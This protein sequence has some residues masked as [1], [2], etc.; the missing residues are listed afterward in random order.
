ME[1][2]EEKKLNVAVVNLEVMKLNKN[3]GIYLILNKING[4]GYVG[5][6]SQLK[7]RKKQHFRK[8]SKNIHYND[9]LQNAF[10]K[11]GEDSFRFLI[12]EYCSE[13]SLP[14]AEQE[15]IKML[16]TYQN[17]YNLTLGG[18]QNCG[19]YLNEETRKIM[20]QKAKEGMTE[21]RRKHLSEVH[22]GKKHSE[23]T[24]EK[25]SKSHMGKKTSKK[26]KHKKSKQK[27]ETGIF[28]LSIKK[29]DSSHNYNR[30]RYTYYKDGKRKTLL[31]KDL[32]AIYDF[33]LENDLEWTILDDQKASKFLKQLEKR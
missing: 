8:L 9:H 29:P 7:E 23:E 13:D 26:T 25:M 16:N 30:F 15:W 1:L 20:S 6:S 19:F 32:Q 22:T 2:Q 11:Y 5:L 4:K 31:R 12:L 10:N 33:V 17:G 27:T 14:I 24:K 28:R 3:C 21:E 18:E